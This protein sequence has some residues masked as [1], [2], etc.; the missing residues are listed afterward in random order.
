MMAYT[1]GV[2]QILQCNEQSSAFSR[3]RLCFL[4]ARQRQSAVLGDVLL[5][6]TPQTLQNPQGLTIRDTASHYTAA[7]I[8][9]ALGKT[10][11][12]R[13][14]ALLTLALLVGSAAGKAAA[15]CSA[16]Q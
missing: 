11:A 1:C 6:P 12:A 5:L 4:P 9:R 7:T 15:G 14:C 3:S 8:T 13:A 10:M 16:A 2:Q